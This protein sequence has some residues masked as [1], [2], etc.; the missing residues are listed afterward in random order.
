MTRKHEPGVD[1]KPGESTSHDGIE[2]ECS[3]CGRPIPPTETLE[4][5]V[6]IT[7]IWPAMEVHRTGCQDIARVVKA[8]HSKATRTVGEMSTT[9]YTGS[10]IVAAIKA[11][12]QDMADSFCEEAYQDD[13]THWTVRTCST[14]PCMS[15]MLKGVAFDD[16][17]RPSWKTDPGL[18]EA[19]RWQ[20]EA[21][22]CKV[23]DRDLGTEDPGFGHRYHRECD[24]YLH[25]QCQCGCGYFPKGKNSRFLPG[26]DAR[27]QKVATYR[28]ANA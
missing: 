1:C 11:A 6:S 27:R 14:A 20:C 10:D 7:I 3:I 23:G 19:Y 22:H 21:I 18:G 17:G 8:S 26:H 13:M 28:A 24:P 15:A 4:V 9:V 2:W 12:D 5:P 25:R 16:R